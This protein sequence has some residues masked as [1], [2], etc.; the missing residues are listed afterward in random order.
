MRAI[1]YLL[2][3]C[4]ALVTLRYVVMLAVIMATLALGYSLI[5]KPRE[6]VSIL[7]ALCVISLFAHSPVVFA[8]TFAAFAGIGFAARRKAG[9]GGPKKT[10]S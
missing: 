9:D 4:V 2:I 1:S 8:T 5:A 6:T 10:E 3:A 7:L